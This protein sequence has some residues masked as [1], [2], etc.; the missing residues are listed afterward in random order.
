M[1]LGVSVFHRDEGS[2]RD[3]GGYEATASFDLPL[4]WGL[5]RAGKAKPRRRLAASLGR[6]GARP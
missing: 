5:R 4:Q 6:P 1:T 3:F 2:D